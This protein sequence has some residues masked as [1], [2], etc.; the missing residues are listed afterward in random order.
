MGKRVTRR[1]R[2]KEPQSPKPAKESTFTKSRRLFLEVLGGIATLLTIAGFFLDHVP[3]ISV[4]AAGSLQSTSPMG[5]VFYLSN[6]GGLPIHDVEV[7]FGNVEIA[8][9]GFRVE[10]FGLEYKA[11]TEARADKLSPGHKMTLPYAYGFGFMGVGN[12]QGAQMTIRVHYRPD[13]IPW[14]KI[15]VFPFET[16][17]AANGTWIWK[18][19]PK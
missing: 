16:I 15:E 18:N 7:T 17:R 3:K 9:Q 1:K 2:D 5:A 8:G 12:L 13:W 4:D 19:I 14:H 11:P 6:D 10:G